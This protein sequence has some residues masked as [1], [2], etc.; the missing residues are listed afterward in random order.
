MAKGK[1]FVVSGPSGVGKTT[2]V[3]QAIERLSKDYD[4]E[5]I[6]TYTSRPPREGEE[7]GQDYIFIS[8]DE[9]KQKQQDRFFLETNEYE[10][11][12]YGSPMPS[13][14]DMELGKSFIMILDIDLQSY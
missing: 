11:H 8:S 6:V 3:R 13:T 5:R 12:S 14:Q 10:N 1:L 4:I 2:I 9:F 7:P